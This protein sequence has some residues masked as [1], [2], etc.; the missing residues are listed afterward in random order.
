M[1]KVFN[2]QYSENTQK[3]VLRNRNRN[4]KNRNRNRRNRNFGLSG[5]GTGTEINRITKEKKR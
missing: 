3:A 1:R 5:T 4:R 2:L